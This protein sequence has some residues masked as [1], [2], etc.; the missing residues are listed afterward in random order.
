VK[1]LLDENLSFRL[2]PLLDSAYPGTTHVRDVGLLGASDERIWGHAA[3]HGFLL[4]SKDADFFQRSSVFG[5]PPKVLWLRV[6]NA[7]TRAIAS[8]LR[9]R[10]V[11]IAHFAESS[12]AALLHLH[13]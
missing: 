7:P 11:L 1:L 9:E 13:L 5:A 4:A 3:E 12:P 8:L 10:Y 2:V 6:G